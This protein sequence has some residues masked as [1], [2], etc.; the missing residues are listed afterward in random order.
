MANIVCKTVNVQHHR[1]LWLTATYL[2]EVLDRQVKAL[3]AFAS[4]NTHNRLGDV[5]TRVH[6]Q[7]AT[8]TTNLVVCRAITGN[9]TEFLV[10]LLWLIMLK[11]REGRR[12]DEEA[13]Q[14]TG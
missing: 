12:K 10:M 1:L 2:E 6:A 4:N 3:P 9:I 13:V 11:L 14:E 8:L 7:R 5:N